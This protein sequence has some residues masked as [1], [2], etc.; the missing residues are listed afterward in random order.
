MGAPNMQQIVVRNT[1]ASWHACKKSSSGR[2]NSPAGE[3]GNTL[4]AY[5]SDWAHFRMVQP[6]RTR[7]AAGRAGHGRPLY[8]RL[9]GSGPS[10]VHDSAPACVHQRR[11]SSRRPPVAHAGHA[12]END[13]GRYPSGQGHRSKAGRSR[14]HRTP[15]GYRRRL[16]ARHARRPP[17]QGASPCRLHRRFPPL[18]IGRPQRRDLT[19]TAEGFGHAAPL[20]TDQEGEG[21]RRPFH[22]GRMRKRAQLGRFG[23][24]LT[25]RHHVRA[26]FRAVNRHGQVSARRL[27][28]RAVALI[29]KRSVEA[30]GLDAS[31]S[32][33]TRCG[34]ASPRRPPG[35]APVKGILPASRITSPTGFFDATFETP[36]CSITQRFPPWDCRRHTLAF[37]FDYQPAP[38]F[39]GCIHLPQL[40]WRHAL[41]QL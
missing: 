9:G 3:G 30:V 10:R 11:S 27:S 25:P 22:T 24:G 26:V 40:V 4:R 12:G 14:R 8:H 38:E 39:L 28:D 7:P 6:A 36:K 20:K 17:R 29:V 31:G 37:L 19:P 34:Q 41:Q 23:H 32:A 13:M 18:G 2:G 16:A 15:A 21:K 1:P 5:R 35:P 33:A